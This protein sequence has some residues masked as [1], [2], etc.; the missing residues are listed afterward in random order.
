MPER[1]FCGED[2]LISW[3]FLFLHFV[4]PFRAGEQNGFSAKFGEF[5]TRNGLTKCKN[6]NGYE[7]NWPSPQK[8][9]TGMTKSFQDPP[10]LERTACKVWWQSVRCG[11][12][13]RCRRVCLR[14]NTNSVGHF[15]GNPWFFVPHP[16]CFSGARARTKF[17][18]SFPIRSGLKTAVDLP[19]RVA[20]SQCCPTGIFLSPLT[21]YGT[22]QQ[23]G[24][25]QKKL[26]RNG[27]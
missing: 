11:Q 26:A 14:P 6:K 17:P 13:Y 12:R 3:P 20:C 22:K 7:I 10:R 25:N 5:L 8:N 27:G 16:P 23:P 19:A 15:P 4:W 21:P 24:V 1:F 2:Q 18:Y 9:R